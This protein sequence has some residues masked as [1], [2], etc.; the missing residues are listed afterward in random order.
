LNPPRLGKRNRLTQKSYPDT[1]AVNYTYDNN[2]NTLT[3]VVGTNTT[4]YAWDYE[5][6]L[7]SVT[8]PGSGGTVAFKYDPI[9]RRIYKSS[10][11]S[12]SVFA[13]N[14]DNLIEETNATGTVVA[15]YEQGLNIDEPLAM[16][17]SSTTSFYQA[18]GLG[19]ITSLTNGTGSVANS[20]T[21]DSFGNL[22]AS[23][24]TLVNPFRYTARESDTETG[25]YY[26]RARY[27]DS[28][29]GRFLTEDPAGFDVGTDFYPYAGNGPT[30]WKDPEGLR[31]VQIC[32]QP[33]ESYKRKY[34]T[35]IK[36]EDDNGQVLID[37]VDHL[38]L[39]YGILGKRK[40]STENQQVKKGDPRNNG[41]DCKY[42]KNCDETKIDTLVDA[43]ET[44]W[45]TQSC[46]SCGHH[47]RGWFPTIHGIDGYNSNT[48]TFN[49]TYNAGMEPPRIDDAPGYHKAQGLW[50]PQ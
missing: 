43:L 9:G 19:S 4:S 27:Y 41:T 44:A 3:K 29:T 16:L 42:V 10:S 11:S 1:T 26:Y 45:A 28:T 32:R 20:Y 21:D 40:G 8:L 50:Y 2:G 23:T 7:T 17:R 22:T 12:T 48:Y 47:Y 46:A 13:Y 35:Y 49:M 15:R 34:H 6:R 18:D 31:R 5:N 14:G 38:E 36:I 25:L 33:V 30:N 24:G 39:T 37:S